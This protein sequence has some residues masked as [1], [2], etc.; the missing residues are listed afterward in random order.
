MEQLPKK[1]RLKIYLYENMLTDKKDEFFGKVDTSGFVTIEE[2]ADMLVAGGSRYTR[3]QLLGAS[4]EIAQA[5]FTSV[6]NGFT[7]KLKTCTLRATISGTFT[8][9]R[10]QFDPNQHTIGVSCSPSPHARE[11]V[12]KAVVTV[13]GLAPAVMYIN[14]VYDVKSGEENGRLTCGRSLKIYGGRL[15]IQ[16]SDPKVGV[17]FVSATD[18]LVRV[19]VESDDIVDNTPSQLT[20]V[21]PTLDNGEWYL[22]VTTQSGK[23]KGQLLKEARTTRFEIPLIV[24]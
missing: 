6:A 10:A 19:P 23:G 20:V 1:T 5:A 7:V 2:L 16:G 15:T 14:R 11:T 12:K 22:E 13:S 4:D 21:V 9:A 24:L 8:G 3:E 18:E 17:Q